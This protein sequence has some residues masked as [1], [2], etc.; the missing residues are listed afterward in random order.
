MKVEDL[1]TKRVVTIHARDP[2]NL[3]ALL[4]SENDFGVLPVVNGDGHL[5]GMLTA[6]DICMCTWKKDC[7]LEAIRA[8]EAM[9]P[10]VITVQP[11]QHVKVAEQMMAEHHL[12]RIP[13]VD[14]DGRPVGILSVA[15]I[16]REAA[17]SKPRLDEGTAETMHVIAAI[18]QPKKHARP[19]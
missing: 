6:R 19:T 11:D 14:G 7:V 15:D 18:L 2:L 9:S 3:A 10:E 4:M 16:A 8:D 1:M 13:V 17:E 12:R 5:I